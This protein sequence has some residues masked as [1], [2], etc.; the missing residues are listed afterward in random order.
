MNYWKY[1]VTG[2]V[3]GLF[4]E[5]EFRLL[6]RFTPG[7]LCFAVIFYPIFVS[8]AYFGGKLV[9]A[10]VQRRYLADVM[11]YIASGLCGLAVEWTLL[12]NSPWSNPKAVQSAMFC[13][14]AAFCFGPRVLLRNVDQPSV[15]RKL[16]WWLLAIYGIVSLGLVALFRDPGQRFVVILL[17]TMGVYFVIN[18]I[19]ILITV[20]SWRRGGPVATTATE[21]S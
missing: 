19:L 6:G 14:W 17:S 21:D 1:V 4:I 3:L 16:V 15:L 5:I 11:C 12:G 13:M 9:D 20:Q 18:M 8:C 10:F 2:C 7:A